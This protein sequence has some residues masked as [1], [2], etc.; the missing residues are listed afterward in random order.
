MLQMKWPLPTICCWLLSVLP[1]GA[2][3]VMNRP[4]LSSFS[5]THTHSLAQQNSAVCGIRTKEVA[6]CTVDTCCAAELLYL[7]L[8][9]KASPI[10]T[11]PPLYRYQLC[12]APSCFIASVCSLLSHCNVPGISSAVPKVLAAVVRITATENLVNLP[13]LTAR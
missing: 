4:F 6:V 7:Q 12:C 11:W 3:P 2:S 9:D 8:L 13:L 5:P 1:S 10:I